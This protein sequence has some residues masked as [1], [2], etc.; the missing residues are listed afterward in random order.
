MVL[1]FIILMVR[2]LHEKRVMGLLE[3]LM[4]KGVEELCANLKWYQIN[5][6]AVLSVCITNPQY[7]I[8]E[9]KIAF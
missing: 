6:Y 3:K 8:F 5:K 9:E 4:A 1:I 2:Q 7:N